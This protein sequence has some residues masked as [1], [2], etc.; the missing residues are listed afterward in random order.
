MNLILWKCFN[1]ELKKCSI[2]LV[3]GFLLDLLL[4]NWPFVKMEESRVS[5]PTM[6]KA[7]E[8]ATSLF[9]SIAVVTVA[10]CLAAIQPYKYISGRIQVSA[11]L[12]AMCVEAASQQKETSKFI[13]K[14]TRPNFLT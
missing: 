3:K 4:M 11:R 8:A 12:S 14:D 10:R 7:V 5:H 6:G 9:L 2:Q 13:S 1:G